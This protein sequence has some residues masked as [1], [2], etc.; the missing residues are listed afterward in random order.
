RVAET[1][2]GEGL[3]LVPISVELDDLAGLG[4]GDQRVAARET[5]HVPQGGGG[6]GPRLVVNERGHERARRVVELKL[7]HVRRAVSVGVV[8]DEERPIVEQVMTVVDLPALRRTVV[9]RRRALAHPAE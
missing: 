6:G 5:L 7:E 3:Y 1:A 8:E 2:H 4:V 9:S